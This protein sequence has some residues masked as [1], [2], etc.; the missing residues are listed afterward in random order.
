MKDND[1]QELFVSDT[2]IIKLNY[3]PVPLNSFFSSSPITHRPASSLSY[4][5]KT[6]KEY[7]RRVFRSDMTLKWEIKWQ[8][9]DKFHSVQQ[10][11][12]IP[13]ML[14]PNDG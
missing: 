2:E 10:I 12:R 4:M 9:S 13:S 5:I 3:T 7:F 11:V 1:G 6:E 8:T 14:L